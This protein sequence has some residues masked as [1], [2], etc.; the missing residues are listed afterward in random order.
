MSK[1]K[2]QAKMLHEELNKRKQKCTYSSLDVK[3]FV[4]RKQVKLL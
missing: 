3:D 4:E 2:K 1:I